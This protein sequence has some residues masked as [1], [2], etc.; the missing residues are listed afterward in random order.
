[1]VEGGS[2]E[3][4]SRIKGLFYGD[5]PAFENLMEKLTSALM[6]Y[7][8]MQIESG[9]EAIQIF[10][11][12]GGVVAGADYE[13]ASLQWI[14]RLVAAVP[15]GFPVILFAK[16]TSFQHAAQAGSGIRV[17]SVDWT[18]DLPGPVP[19]FAFRPRRPGKSRPRNIEHDTGRSRERMRPP[20]SRHAARRPGH[21][22]N[23]GHGILPEAKIECVEALVQTVVEWK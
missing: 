21:I 13:A 22:V 3:D 12:W 10:D 16:G 19:V 5:R 9:A 23:L 14:R 18:V 11:S 7:L 1:M 15:A 6:V 17:L 2:S 4:F 20:P 8:R